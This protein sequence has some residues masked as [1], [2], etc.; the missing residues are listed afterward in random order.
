MPK[1]Y[2]L[3]YHIEDQLSRRTVV[4]ISTVVLFI[5][6]WGMQ[7]QNGHL[8]IRYRRNFQ[9]NEAEECE[10]LTDYIL[11]YS[12]AR[13]TL[14]VLLA[15]IKFKKAKCEN[16]NFAHRSSF[17]LSFFFSIKHNLK[18]IECMQTQIALLMKIIPT[19]FDVRVGY[20]QPVMA[21]RCICLLFRRWFRNLPYKNRNQGKMFVKLR[22]I[23]GWA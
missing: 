16:F 15:F 23:Q 12:N 10:K 7:V 20:D 2:D 11:Y 14:L 1:I 19:C 8:Y 22:F 3:V 21:S 18:T 9:K 13:S 4:S 5:Q 6:G 17:C